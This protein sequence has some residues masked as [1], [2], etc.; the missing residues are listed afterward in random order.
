MVAVRVMILGGFICG[1]C[2]CG[3]W[4]GPW[5][6]GAFFGGYITAEGASWSIALEK[7]REKFYERDC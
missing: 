1:A 4:F 7:E 2:M 6:A 5:V 3:Y